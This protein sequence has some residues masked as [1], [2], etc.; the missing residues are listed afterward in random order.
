MTMYHLPFA[1]ER[2]VL[3]VVLFASLIFS[4]FLLIDAY[5]SEKYGIY[6]YMDAGL[7]LLL[8]VVLIIIADTYMQINEGLS[9]DTAFP[10]PMWLLWCIAGGADIYLICDVVRR[11]RRRG[12]KLSNHSIRQALNTL[13]SAVCYFAPS[14]AV[15]LCNLQMYRLFRSLAQ[16]DLQ[17]LDELTEALAACDSRSGIVKL[18]HERQTYLF[19]D[20]KAWRYAQTEVAAEGVTYT[21]A[22]FSDVTELY[23]KNLELQQQTKQL[24]KISCELKQLSDNVMKLTKERE[25]LLAKTRLHDQMGAGLIA[26]RQ[27]LQ[28]DR[29]MEERA[30][31][32]SMLRK[33]VNT[34]KNEKEDL[35][36]HS[37]FEEFLHDAA[38]IGV[39]VELQGTLPEPGKLYDVFMV[40]VRESLTN[41]VRHADATRL[42]ISVQEGHTVSV[43]ITN[44]GTI[45][46]GDVVPKGGLLNLHRQ[47]T[48]LGGTLQI[49]SKPKFA[50][51][52]T[53]PKVKEEAR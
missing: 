42:W 31:A 1:V 9:V 45:P 29:A 19:P 22:I 2:S 4:L 48:G 38:T 49:R 37:E 36:E 18:S 10:L 41:S 3:V 5:G 28:Q 32:V 6:T 46:V 39:Q 21:E 50:L 33:A 51:L 11:Y 15:K 47:V 16:S 8:F 17:T 14:G 35:T 7:S 13:P 27:L 23:E 53:I 24:Q 43:C 20:G 52:V 12:K 26:I 34:I 40:A 30:A 25:V 44:D